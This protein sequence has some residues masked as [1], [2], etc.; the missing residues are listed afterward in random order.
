MTD[1]QCC[2]GS[3]TVVGTGIKARFHITAESAAAIKYADKV[4]Y[5]VSDSLTE[6]WMNQ[7]TE[8]SESLVHCYSEG[9]RR[10]E[11]YTEM[12]SLILDEVRKGSRVCAAFY[13]HPAVCVYPSHEAI[14]IAREE[15][16]QTHMQ[17]GISAEACLFSDLGIDPGSR[18]YQSF[19]ATDFLIFKRVFDPRSPLVLWQVGVV[20]NLDY[21]Q[22]GDYDLRY[23]GVLKDV[24]LEH[25]PA[26]HEGVLYYAATISIAEPSIRRIQLSELDRTSLHGGHTLYVPPIA[27][28]TAD[29]DMLERLGL[30]S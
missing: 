19:E 11:S 22:S 18:G 21:K 25:Y 10:L 12:V 26:D 4:F 9:K 23:M 13:G 24:L 16:F 8:R 15:G 29:R 7:V 20:A 6:R 17:P 28:T 14:R 3:L 27:Q 5:L 30:S 2:K 1:S